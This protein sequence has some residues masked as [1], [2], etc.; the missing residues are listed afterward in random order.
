MRA[1]E[2]LAKAVHPGL[3]NIAS[4]MKE[5]Q[6]R[7]I[8]QFKEIRRTIAGS[9]QTPAPMQPKEIPPGPNFDREWILGMLNHHQGAIDMST[10]GHGTGLEARLDSLAHHTIEEQRMEQQELRDSL[11]VWYGQ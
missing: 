2:A 4:R 3:K 9:D 11:R 1:D 8:A 5:D 7:E 10:L 6:G